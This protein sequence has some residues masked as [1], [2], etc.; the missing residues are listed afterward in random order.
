MKKQFLSTL[1]ALALV[2]VMGTSALA[3]NTQ[4]IDGSKEGHPSSGEIDVNGTIGQLDNTKPGPN[5]DP[6]EKWIN[7]TIPVTAIFHSDTTEGGD[8]TDLVSP[9][10][11]IKNNSA[12][13]V[14]VNVSDVDAL[15]AKS[16]D[17]DLFVHEKG[18]AASG[19][20]LVDKGAEASFDENALETLFELGVHESNIDNENWPLTLPNVHPSTNDFEF[21]GKV[22]QDLTAENAEYYPTFT[23]VL[24]FEVVDLIHGTTN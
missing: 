9:S 2:L 15:D 10:Y 8:L 20:Q 18:V 19:I 23:L 7:V 24:K 11:N 12:Q 6:I 5:P 13:G 3:N 14:K 1:L 22:N 21:T 16:V 17:F 4:V